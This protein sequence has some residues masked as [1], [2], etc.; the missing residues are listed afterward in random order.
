MN[1]KLPGKD[2]DNSELN[3]KKGE[4]GQKVT[5]GLR[6]I[7]TRPSVRVQVYDQTRANYNVIELKKSEK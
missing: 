1:T 7:A 5:P 2:T 6:M 4:A 3:N